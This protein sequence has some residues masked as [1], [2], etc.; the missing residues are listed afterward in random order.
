MAGECST[1]SVSKCADEQVCW[2]IQTGAVGTTQEIQQLPSRIPDDYEFNINDIY[3]KAFTWTVLKGY[4]PDVAMDMAEDAFRKV[5]ANDWLSETVRND[6]AGYS[7]SMQERRN[8]ANQFYDNVKG[9]LNLFQFG[10]S[11]ANPG[12]PE[13]VAAFIDE[14]RS[15]ALIC[16]PVSSML[17]TSE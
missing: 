6:Y 9:S 4:D 7:F 16:P 11:E 14:A 2:A 12:F 5:E 1:K 13:N 10:R 15:R 3:E 17:G 8:A